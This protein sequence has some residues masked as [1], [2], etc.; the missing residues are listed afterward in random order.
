MALGCGALRIDPAA[1]GELK[2]MYVSPEARGL[3]SGDSSWTASKRRRAGR[4]CAACAS[5]PASTSRRRSRLY[6]AAGYA[7]REA[8]GEYAPDPL[9]VFMEKI[10]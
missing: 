4:A 3:G 8:F 7:E 5:R 10:L 6:R 2:R 9:S 1:M